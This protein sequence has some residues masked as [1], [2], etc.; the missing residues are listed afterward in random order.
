[1]KEVRLSEERESYSDDDGCDGAPA[2]DYHLTHV[3]RNFDVG[4][5]RGNDGSIGTARRVR[6]VP[7]LELAQLNGL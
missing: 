1:M 7:V 5:S 2:Y 4:R 3:D 6:R